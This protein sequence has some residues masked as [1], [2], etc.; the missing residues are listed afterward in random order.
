MPNFKG[1]REDI[2]SSD[3]EMLTSGK[4]IDPRKQEIDNTTTAFYNPAIKE[5]GA[6]FPLTFMLY[7]QVRYY[8]D[9][10]KLSLGYSVAG[11]PALAKQFKK[12]EKQ[13]Q[14]AFDNLTNKYH[15]GGWVI[16]DEKIFRNV[17]KIWVSNV[18]QA[19]GSMAEALQV[20]ALLLNDSSYGVGDDAE[21]SYGVGAN[22]EKLLQRRSTTPT[23]EELPT[24]V[25]PLS[26]SNIKVISKLSP[27]V[28]DGGSED[29]VIPLAALTTHHVEVTVY[30]SDDNNKTITVKHQVA[31]KEWNKAVR[32]WRKDPA[33][34]VM[35][36]FKDTGETEHMTFRRIKKYNVRP[37][38]RSLGY[39]RN[40]GTAF[41]VSHD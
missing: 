10:G 2:D 23:R 6:N 41:G 7:N 4:L 31:P 37:Q 14:K 24:E 1:S 35:M 5:F 3:D 26:E 12:T 39:D 11:I 20:G 13:I 22:C 17:K 21:N 9:H 19:R 40:A 32:K 18:R 27:D 36:E 38:T 16:C 28:D 33:K 15:L 29:D 30:D 34:S 25:R 8:E